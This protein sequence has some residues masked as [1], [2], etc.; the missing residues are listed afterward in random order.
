[1]ALSC[2]QHKHKSP[3]ALRLRQDQHYLHF[4][5]EIALPF[6]KS[7]ASGCM[8]A[9]LAFVLISKLPLLLCSVLCL[10]VSG[11][12]TVSAGEIKRISKRRLG[13]AATEFGAPTSPPVIG[14]TF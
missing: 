10:F 3:N 4:R 12:A 1:M 6:F 7:E 2:Y 9:P 8:F 14:H 5:A 11:C 13:E